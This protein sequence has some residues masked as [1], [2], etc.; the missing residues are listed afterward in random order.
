MSF[1]TSSVVS[2]VLTI[3]SSSFNQERKIR[4]QLPEDYKES[5][6]FY[7][8]IYLLDG[9]MLFDFLTGLYKYNSDKYPPAILVGIEQT[10]RNYELVEQ[11]KA[12]ENGGMHYQFSEFFLNELMP[13]IDSAYRTNSLN[14]FIGHSHGGHFLLSKMIQSSNINNCICISPTIWFNDY[15]ILD[16]FENFSPDKNVNY[17]LY[18][19]YG[20]N[21]F[22]AIQ[23]GVIKLSEAI[24]SKSF[25]NFTLHSDIYID[26]DHNSA[27]L[28]GM[29]KGLNKMFKDYIFPENKWDIIEETG[30][31]SIF[32]KHF[33]HLSESFN[34]EILP[35]E[36]DLNQLGYFY[37]EAGRVKEAKKT[38]LKNA[39]LHPYSANAYD[40]YGEALVESGDL[41]NALKYFKKAYKMEKESSNNKFQLRQYQDHIDLSK[42]KLHINGINE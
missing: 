14:I 17:K 11:K 33:E 21:D 16:E 5:P 18:F 35:C 39:T 30:D 20:D 22:A 25:G 27:I 37:L 15:N 28:I 2:Q 10:Y 36:D 19:G 3:N 12:K 1:F 9:Q 4:V 23:K 29:R 40:S 24:N 26:E 34:C 41:A 31:D 6:S 32:Y 8:V 13:F 7:P 38:F 42:K